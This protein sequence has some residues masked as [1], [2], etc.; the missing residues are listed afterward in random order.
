VAYAPQHA[1]I[2]HGSVRDNILFGLPYWPARY[3]KVL[4]QASLLPDL[5]TLNDGDLTQI[6]DDGINLVSIPVDTTDGR[7]GD[8]RPE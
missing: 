4:K 3:Q 1:Y 7:A 5:E 8:K 2:K 6:G